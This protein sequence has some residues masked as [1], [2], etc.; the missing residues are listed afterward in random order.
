MK[1][2]GCG[3]AAP[4]FSWNESTGTTARIDTRN[5]MDNRLALAALTLFCLSAR[6]E[7]FVVTRFDD[8]L[9][10]GCQPGDCSLRE[11]A[12]AAASNDAFG[13]DDAIQLGAG[14]YTLIRGELP[15]GSADQKL[16]IAG[17]GSTATHVTTDAPLFSALTD[18]SL[19]VRGLEFTSTAGTAFHT[20]AR[21]DDS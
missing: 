1:R 8:P 14:A 3:P 5:E 15:W 7:T 21:M 2:R 11:A 19:R 9:P 16:E 6:A 12:T 4:G 17:A 10:D 18:R 20:N 13:G